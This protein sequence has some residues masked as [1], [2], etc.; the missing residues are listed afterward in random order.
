MEANNK[1][2]TFKDTLSVLTDFESSLRKNT[3][4]V[5]RE[6]F[7]KVEAEQKAL[8]KKIWIKAVSC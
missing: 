2:E 7:N 1:L 6:T 5:S 3:G 4:L 8:I